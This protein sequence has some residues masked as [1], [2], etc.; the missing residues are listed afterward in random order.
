MDVYPID[1][2]P[3]W[4]FA[5]EH[6]DSTP[7]TEKTPG[8]DCITGNVAPPPSRIDVANGIKYT[9]FSRERSTVGISLEDTKMLRSMGIENLPLTIH[10]GLDIVAEVLRRKHIYPFAD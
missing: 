6:D 3:Y 10:D 4:W 1:T 9:W 5:D 8:I 2:V 7:G